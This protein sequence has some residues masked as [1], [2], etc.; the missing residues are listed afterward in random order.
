[1]WRAAVLPAQVEPVVETS[2]AGDVYGGVLPEIGLPRLHECASSRPRNAATGYGS[3]RV[4]TK[5]FKN[6]FIKCFKY[7]KDY[8]VLMKYFVIYL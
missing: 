6:V 4:F 2:G 3:T 7:V 5:C 1:M 8:K